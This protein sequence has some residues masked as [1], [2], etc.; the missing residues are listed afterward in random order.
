MS[1][2]DHKVTLTVAGPTT[3]EELHRFME[4]L[5]QDMDRSTSGRLVLDDWEVEMGEAP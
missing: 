4:L 5:A 2:Y 1:K 3:P